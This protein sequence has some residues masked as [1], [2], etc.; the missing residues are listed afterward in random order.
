MVLIGG[1]LTLLLIVTLVM[2]TLRAEDR[3]TASGWVKNLT[4]LQDN[5]TNA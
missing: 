5:G 2:R 4:H 3:L 1:A